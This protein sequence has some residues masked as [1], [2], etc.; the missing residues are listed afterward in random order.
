MLPTLWPGDIAEIVA[1]S[2]S[3]VGRGE[4]VLAFREDRF[5]MHRFLARGE[6]A[7]FIT[8]GDS[9]PGPDPAFPAAALLGKL[10]TVFRDGQPVALRSRPWS[11]M[12]GMLFCYCGMARCAAL[13]FRRS[14]KFLRLP[15]VDVE[16]A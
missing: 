7:G 5:F 8:R 10:V 9:M 3:D 4:I 12:L 16:T 13:K 1:C 15:N 11:R 14:G 2:V 6:H